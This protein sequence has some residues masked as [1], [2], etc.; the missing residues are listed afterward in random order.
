MSPL[1]IPLFWQPCPWV[2]VQNSS[3]MHV[4]N[5][6]DGDWAT[7]IMWAPDFG[8]SS[9]TNGSTA[10]KQDTW[11]LE[12]RRNFWNL[13]RINEC[14]INVQ[15]KKSSDKFFCVCKM[16]GFLQEKELGNNLL[17]AGANNFSDSSYL[18]IYSIF[19][20]LGGRSAKQLWTTIRFPDGQF[21]FQLSQWCTCWQGTG[22][23][24]KS[25]YVATIHCSD[26]AGHYG[27]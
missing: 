23:R 21:T 4:E 14:S 3:V 22:L 6:V 13:Q 17:S 2:S 12:K 5:V 24:A 11:M 15:H 18:L 25:W 10:F 26:K 20:F 9:G 7:F 19:L 16:L 27:V 8:P 1:T